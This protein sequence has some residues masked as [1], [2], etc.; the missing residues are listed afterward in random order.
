M[1]KY[2]EQKFIAHL[3]NYTRV[4]S[5]INLEDSKKVSTHMAAGRPY[6]KEQLERNCQLNKLLGEADLFLR[7]MWE[8]V[9]Y[10]NDYIHEYTAFM[11]L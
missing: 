8:Y 7:T 9:T 1:I 11:C 2:L 10:Q 4:K 6:K 3:F 5:C